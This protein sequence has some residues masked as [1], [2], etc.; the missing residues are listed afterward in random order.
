MYALVY[1]VTPLIIAYNNILYCS[2][3]SLDLVT[4]ELESSYSNRAAP[5]ILMEKETATPNAILDFW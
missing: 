2:F 3:P 4:G 5:Q 1:F